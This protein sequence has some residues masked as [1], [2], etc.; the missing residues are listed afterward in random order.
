VLPLSDFDDAE[1]TIDTDP[2]MG[3]IIVKYERGLSRWATLTCAIACYF[4]SISALRIHG[5]KNAFIGRDAGLRLGDVIPDPPLLVL[6]HTDHH[7]EPIKDDRSFLWAMSAFNV[8]LRWP[9]ASDRVCP[10]NGIPIGVVPPDEKDPR[11]SNDLANLLFVRYRNF[12]KVCNRHMYQAFISLY[13][14]CPLLK[15]PLKECEEKLVVPFYDDSGNF[16]LGRVD[17]AL[18][19]LDLY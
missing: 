15:M 2:P 16:L 5:D 3:V 6:T 8:G 1:F 13:Q 17:Y 14:R 7:D 4:P 9:L 19:V 10:L 12:T 18:H 11:K